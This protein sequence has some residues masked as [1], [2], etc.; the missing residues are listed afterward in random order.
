M[1]IYMTTVMRLS[2]TRKNT[3]FLC[4]N[5]TK[6][7]KMLSMERC[8]KTTNDTFEIRFNSNWVYS[9]LHLK[10]LCE[11]ELIWKRKTAKQWQVVLDLKDTKGFPFEIISKWGRKNNKETACKHLKYT[12]ETIPILLNVT[13]NNGVVNMLINIVVQR[14]LR[15]IHILWYPFI[16]SHDSNQAMITFVWPALLNN[17]TKQMQ[18]Y[19]SGKLHGQ[20]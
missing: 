14:I 6:S 9:R 4:L 3:W 12:K 15:K 7:S 20:M 2:T 1:P 11:V 13:L 10:L 17:N 16:L 8:W 5:I 18:L 19:R